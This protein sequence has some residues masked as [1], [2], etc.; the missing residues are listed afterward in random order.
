MCCQ[1]FLT[2][3]YQMSSIERTELG[4]GD[5]FRAE[6]RQTEEHL[7]KDRTE[8][9]LFFEKQTNLLKRRWISQKLWE[10][11]KVSKPSLPK[12]EL[13]YHLC[14]TRILWNYDNEIIVTMT[15]PQWSTVLSKYKVIWGGRKTWQKQ[16]QKKIHYGIRSVV[17]LLTVEFSVFI[18]KLSIDFLE[19][20]WPESRQEK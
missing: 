7:V 8:K 13:S 6:N 20:S 2:I 11:T 4:R 15:T 12:W 1:K 3:D 10:I 19:S 18:E 9:Y 5:I 16:N 14:F 17:F